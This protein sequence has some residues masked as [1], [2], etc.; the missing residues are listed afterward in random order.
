T[1]EIGRGNRPTPFDLRYRRDPPLVPR[2]LRFEIGGR[3]DGQGNEI[4][5]LDLE[6]LDRLAETFRKD[7]VEAVAISFLNSYAAPGH[8]TEAARR[9]RN[10]LPDTYVSA[11]TELSREWFEY[12]RSATVSANAFVGPMVA[13]YLG[14]FETTLRDRGYDGALYMMGSNGG[15]L[16]AARARREPVKLVESGPA[17]GCIGAAAFARSLGLDNV[18]AFDM[19]GTTAKC[20]LISKGRFSVENATYIG[21]FETGFPIRAA[22]IDIVEIG[23]GGGSIAALDAQNRLHVGPRSAGAEPGPACYGRGGSDP[24][25]TDANLILGRL[26]PDRFLGGE[27]TLDVNAARDALNNAIA[28]PLGYE[29]EDGLLH[30]ADG[31]VTIAVDRMAGAIR[32]ISVERGLDPRDFALLTYGGGGPLHASALAHALDIPQVI[33]PPEPGN[34]SA[35]GM[36]LANARV[37]EARTYLC[38]LDEAAVARTRDV[39]AEMA[40]AATAQLREE[41]AG[42]IDFDYDAEM[43]YRGQKHSIRIAVGELDSEAALRR[44]FSEEYRR[45]YGHADEAA[46]IEYVGLHLGAIMATQQPDVARLSRLQEDTSATGASRPVCLPQD[47]VPTETAIYDRAALAPGFSAH[48]P[49]IIEEYGSTTLIGKSDRFEIGALGEI[50]I[51]CGQ[52]ADHG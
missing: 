8:E 40:E 44:A 4:E 41:A 38:L 33:V 7:G 22:V 5:P 14:Q 20:T 49:A 10:Q 42:D 43:R 16:S 12:E 52:G 46:I 17:G 45:R 9:L 6:G 21:G 50:R 23:T 39:F 26:D 19:G 34:F 3:I 29:G 36:L 51:S 2:P 27:L 18:I 47:T 1:L 11:G 24:T 30:M 28:A 48:G 13:E 32:K 25:V 15:V 37:D 31:V 35:T